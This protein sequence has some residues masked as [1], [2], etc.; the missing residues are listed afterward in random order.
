MFIFSDFYKKSLLL[1]GT[2]L[3][4][5]QLKILQNMREGRQHRAAALKPFDQLTNTGQNN[6][7]KRIAKEIYT[8][9]ETIS[10]NLCH[11]LNKPTFKSMTF[12]IKDIVY[13]IQF[14]KE[15]LEQ[16]KSQAQAVVQSCDLG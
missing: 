12:D 7:A 11:T 15:N 5:I 1:S 8:D 2:L 16:N 14:G 4:G 10:T 3:F 6:R 9:F 13:Q